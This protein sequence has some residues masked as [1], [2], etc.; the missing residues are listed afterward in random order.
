MDQIITNASILTMDATA[1]RV[2]SLGVHDGRIAAVGD[3]AGVRA[4]LAPDAAVIDLRGRTVVPGFIDGHTHFINSTF[5]AVQVDCSTPPLATLEEVLERLR[6]AAADATPGQWIRGWGFHWARVRER[7]NPTRTDLDAITSEHPIVVMDASYHGCFVNSRG[8]ELAGIDRHTSPQGQG[9]IVLDEAGDPTGELFETSSDGPAALSWRSYAERSPADAIALVEANARRHLALGITSVSDALVTP[10][11]AAL[12]AAVAQ[13]G[14]LPIDLHQMLGGQ[15]FFGAPRLGQTP[16]EESLRTRQGRL[17]AGTVKMFMD[18]VHPGPAIDRRMAD[19]YR[20]TGRNFYSR[21][22]AE[23]LVLDI[24]DRGFEPAVHALGSCGLEQALA[25]FEA[26][27]RMPGRDAASLRIEHFIIATGEQVSRTASLGVK[28][29]VNPGFVDRWGDMYLHEWRGDGTDW[30]ELRIIPIRSLLASGV[31]VAAGSD[32]PCAPMS[33]LACIQAAVTRMS[34]TGEV[35]DACEAIDPLEG[36]CLYTSSAAAVDGRSDIG[37]IEI[38]K[39][40]NL[41]VLDADPTAVAPEAIGAI[42]VLQTWVD[43]APAF[44]AAQAAAQ[45]RLTV[46]SAVPVSDA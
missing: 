31:T 24:V 34:M 38:G 15:T 13:A 8:L 44:T 36:L 4:A 7:H 6:L 21:A 10:E 33:P 16:T 45:S 37:T 28:A 39:R 43:G 14:R 9:I 17:S 23:A 2:R 46:R 42:R 27:R 32:Y 40:A 30:D 25:A 3:E 22:E 5:E 1:R 41:A 26:V 11:G 19:G 29:V 12:Y 20:H 18:V 35:V